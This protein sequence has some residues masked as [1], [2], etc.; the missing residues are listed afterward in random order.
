[1]IF[2]ELLNGMANQARFQNRA[3]DLY[4]SSGHVRDWLTKA[5]S[6]HKPIYKMAEELRKTAEFKRPYMKIMHTFISQISRVNRSSTL[7]GRE[8]ENLSDVLVF[9]Q[10][11]ELTNESFETI[12]EEEVVDLKSLSVNALQSMARAED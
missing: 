10:T 3:V 2:A 7:D 1:M 11:F 9:R 4:N 6:V 8:I 12:F 5:I